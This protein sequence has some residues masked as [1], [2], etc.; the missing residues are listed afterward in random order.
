VFNAAAEGKAEAGIGHATRRVFRS[1]K[2]IKQ[3][4]LRRRNRETIRC[5]SFRLATA[6]APVII[7]SLVLP[8][9][10]AQDPDQPQLPQPQPPG[11]EAS[12]RDRPTP[13]VPDR[14]AAPRPIYLSGSVRLADGTSPPTSVLI[15]RVCSNVVRPEAY[16]NAKG[17]F[18]FMVGGQEGAIFADASVGGSDPLFQGPDSIGPGGQRG[19]N[20]RE[21]TGCEIRANLPGFLSDSITLTFM[22][23]MDDSEIGVI[24]LRQLGNV[25]GF[26]FSITTASAPRDA[27]NAYEKGL[28]HIKRRRW[29]DAEKELVKAVGIYP[30]YAIAWYELGRV[31]HQQKKLDD[32]KRAHSEAIR[33]DPKFISPY[34]QLALLAAVQEAWEDVVKYTS[35]MLRLNPF[36]T[37]D[38][39]FYSAVANYNLQDADLAEKHAREAARLDRNRQIPKIYH[40]LGILLVQRQEYKEAAEHLQTYLKVSPNA[41]DSAAVKQML[42]EIETAGEKPQP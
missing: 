19:V 29:P 34:G 2:Q 42:A 17:D 25:E 18:S 32:A 1:I 13:A 20:P 24:R 6:L 8:V 30:R 31:Y 3:N 38:I 39:Y 37:P 21:L 9:C 26:T 15:E 11:V 22:T 4:W 16:T 14:S 36:V 7:G 28:D 10:F 5:M 33:N 40:L 27:R 41:P 23:A 12:G 35:Q